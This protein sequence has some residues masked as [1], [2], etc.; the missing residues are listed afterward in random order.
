MRSLTKTI[1]FVMTGAALSVGGYFYG[2]YAQKALPAQG[3]LQSTSAVIKLGVWD[4]FDVDKTNR[5][6][7]I[8]TAPNGKQYMVNKT[9]SLDEW[10]YV[11]FPEDFSPYPD[12]SAYTLYSW[13]CVVGEKTVAGGKFKWGNGQADDSNR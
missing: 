10:V 2:T 13:K 3:F 7:F 9:E 8:V 12:Y 5:A 11:S 1:A 6:T 4:K